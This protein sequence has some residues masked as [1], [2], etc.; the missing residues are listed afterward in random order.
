MGMY[1]QDADDTLVPKYNCL[2]YDAAYPDHCVSPLL[3]NN[4]LL[5]PPTI[6]W[7][8]ASND[9]AGTAY[10]LEPY[11]KNDAVRL[12]PSRKVRPP[13]AGE[14][15]D[16]EGRYVINAWDTYYAK[17]RGGGVL[18]TSPQGRPDA[19]VLE[20]SGTLLV[21]EH[22]NN[23]G[24]CQNGQESGDATH[25][26]ETEGHWSDDHSGGFNALYCDGHVKR[27]TFSQLRRRDFTIQAD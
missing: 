16:A 17:W 22:N 9:P 15:R 23:A 21:W 20:P 3:Q 25:P 19:E 1:A 8:P 13:L 5:D 27:L 7:L 11:I 6:Q 24:E 10:L 4:G 12:C 26:G 14:A 2:Q 18:E